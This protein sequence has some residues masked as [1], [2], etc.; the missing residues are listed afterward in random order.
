MRSHTI[1]CA[2]SIADPLCAL[3]HQRLS[4]S[5]NKESGR[6]DVHFLTNSKALCLK[7]R[8]KAERYLENVDSFAT[9]AGV[10]KDSS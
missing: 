9:G 2:Y 8:E 1:F 3:P 5:K 10:D 4:Q 7:L 6:R